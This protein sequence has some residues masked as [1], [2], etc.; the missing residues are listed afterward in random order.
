MKR[1]WWAPLP[2]VFLIGIGEQK[3][4]CHRPFKT[5]FVVAWVLAGL[6]VVGF[7][8]TGSPKKRTPLEEPV[9]LPT[10]VVDLIP[11]PGP[12]PTSPPGTPEPGV[13]AAKC[14][15]EPD[16]S[17]FVPAYLETRNTQF[18]EVTYADLQNKIVEHCSGCHQAPNAGSGNFRYAA[19]YEDQE[20]YINGEK[21]LVPGIQS[22]ARQMIASMNPE[23]GKGNNGITTMPKGK[24]DQNPKYFDEMRA[25][26]E[27]WAGAN[28]PKDKFYI[29]QTDT[30][31]GHL[32][33]VNASKF[34]S[35]LGN[36]IPKTMGSD[37]EKDAFFSNTKVLPEKLSQT[38]LFSLDSLELAEKGTVSYNV[39]YPLWADNAD[40]GRY[41]HLP[42]KET[43]PGKWEPI[44]AQYNRKTLEF[45]LP[46]NTRLYKTFYRSIV[47]K[48]GEIKFR[49]IETRLILVRDSLE[50]HLMASYKWNPEET[51][52]FLQSKVYRDGSGWQDDS[53]E[54]TVND[55]TQKKRLYAIPGYQRCVDC[56]QGNS[57]G[58]LG[59]SALQLNRRAFGEAGRDFPTQKH[60]LNQIER[61]KSF[62]VLAGFESKKE[63]PELE[64][65]A[66]FGDRVPRNL[67]EM[68]LQ[69]YMEGNCA[70]CHTENGLA[71]KSGVTPLKLKFPSLYNISKTAVV[72]RVTRTYVD[73]TQPE[74]SLIY[75]RV[76]MEGFNDEDEVPMPM[77][78]PGGAAC[79]L[80]T[81]VANWLNAWPG[82]T[83]T[84]ENR[85]QVKCEP[86]DS[87]FWLDSDFTSDKGPYVPRRSDWADPEKGMP[88]KFRNLVETEELKNLSKSLFPV[89]FYDRSQLQKCNFPDDPVP[90]VLPNWALSNGKLRQPWGS[91]FL[92]SPGNFFYTEVCHKC[93]GKAGDAKAAIAT[94]LAL[95]TGG[96]KRVPSFISG[97][98]GN[99]LK[100]LDIF[101]VPV[102]GTSETKNLGGNYLIWMAMEGTLFEF[103]K[104]FHHYLGENKAQMLKTLRENCINLLKSHP[105]LPPEIR[106]N[107][108]SYSSEL[109]KQICFYNN[110][111]YENL[112]EELQ[113]YLI[114]E[115]EPPQPRNPKA[116]E[117]W[118]DRAAY[119][120]G[121]AI[122]EYL[123]ADLASGKLSPSPSACELR[124]PLKSK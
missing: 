120:I 76:A 115:N 48:S 8:C 74:K 82:G 62:G 86:N 22:T 88:E 33:Y 3:M 11:D 28:Y 43:E 65:Q 1:I 54:L 2:G 78:T 123:K 30:N 98:V 52:A 36:C 77:H 71:I 110:S 108:N 50:T 23:R 102:P 114:S 84:P 92:I 6:T 66:F 80:K 72:D 19:S 112:P 4:R 24:Y 68:K 96:E 51:E 9:P 40:K 95:R 109:Y 41:I 10:K 42:S 12:N 73:N 34:N 97:L 57:T 81:L 93:H 49:K 67:E 99:D 26:L 32:P 17:V 53:F 29:P 83:V 116:L 104:S 37:P 119:N 121:W 45:D 21:R 90:E 18:K 70:H 118:A 63:L 100:N 7:G 20:M 60:E 85:I 101:N 46:K 25:E 79:R 38:D 107:S 59:F 44:P 117:E 103:P 111:S 87:F 113:Y 27:Y 56:H 55:Q 69:G 39:E 58:I 94:K 75:K 61:L 91:R 89:G 105:S 5:F 35:D 16:T 64:N 47:T 31:T 106:Q 124:H 13:K 122:F 15:E 14:F